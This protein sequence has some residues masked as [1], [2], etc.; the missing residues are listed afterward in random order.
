MANIT[1]NE[2]Y[3]FQSRMREMIEQLKEDLGIT[4]S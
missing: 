4:D 2:F 1:Y 3:P